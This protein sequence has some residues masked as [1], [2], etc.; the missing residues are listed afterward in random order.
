MAEGVS[1]SF[2]LWGTNYCSGRL[3]YTENYDPAKNTSTLTVKLEVASTAWT[4][5]YRLG[6]TIKAGGVT[7]VDFGATACTV[8][9]NANGNYYTA[10]TWTSGEIAHNVDGSQSI[11]IAVNLQGSGS[12]APTWYMTGSKTVA[13]TNIPRASTVGATAAN[14]GAVSTVT[15]SRKSTAYTHTLAY[16]FGSLTGYLTAAGGTSTTAAKLTATSIAFTVPTSFYAQIPNAKTGTCTLTCTT[17]SGST[18]IGAAQTCSFAVTAPAG[19]CAPTVSGTVVDTNAATK[20]LTG[21]E[22]RLVRYYSTALC[23]IAAAA[24]NAATIASRAI[25]GT[26]LTGAATTRSIAGVTTGSFAFSATDSRGYSATATVT[27]TLINYV[28]LT[29]N[30]TAS[31]NGPTTG[32]AT[33]KLSGNYFAGSFGAASNTLTVSYQIAPA[34]GSFGAAVALTPSV[35]N[36]TWSATASLTGLTYT[37]AWTVRV[38]VADKLV[39]VTKDVAVS[40][41]VPVFDW[42]TDNFRV[43]GTVLVNKGDWNQIQMPAANGNYAILETNGSYAS[44]DMRTGASSADRR[45]LRVFN[46]GGNS[47]D[48]GV[49]YYET[50]NGASTSYKLYGEHNKPTPAAIGALATSGGTMTGTIWAGAHVVFANNYGVQ[51]RTTTGTDY[52]ILYVSTSDQAVVGIDNLTTVIRGKTMQIRGVYG[53]TTTS[54]ANM[55]VNSS[56]AVNRYASSSR[57]YKHDIGPIQAPALDPHRLYD[58]PVRQFV[59]NGDYLASGDQRYG[60]AVPGFIAEEVAEHYPVA[61]DLDD[62]GRP[63]DWGAKWIIPGLLRLVQEQNERIKA[64]EALA[65]AGNQHPGAINAPGAEC[66]Q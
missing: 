24:K 18:Q 40:R 5:S 7:V 66:V 61:A 34:G 27:K 29:C 12:P 20:A 43:N 9:T 8:T 11:A 19:A 14:I 65:G 45:G 38:K 31:R 33:L 48:A 15:V 64:L 59:Y 30:A 50:K 55:T 52:K 6:G 16:K 41:G 56:H 3:T 25:A 44:L 35:G 26:A 51:G 54:A 39:T 57:R 49:L 21:D 1:G 13:L 28:P 42:G 60:Q 46:A 53:N 17:Y 58:L 4:V 2:T 10:G 22:N 47:A 36:G 63:E 37:D 32:N 62:Q 23:T